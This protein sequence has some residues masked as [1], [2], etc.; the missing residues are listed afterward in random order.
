MVHQK[1]KHHPAIKPIL[2]GGT[3]IQYGARTLNEGGIQVHNN[4]DSFCC[5]NQ[6]E[7]FKNV[8]KSLLMPH[9]LYVVCQMDS[10]LTFN[11]SDVKFHGIWWFDKNLRF[12]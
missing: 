6:L 9:T 12:E 8:E 5:V 10:P 11:I 2:E 4:D 3:V 1:L 7:K